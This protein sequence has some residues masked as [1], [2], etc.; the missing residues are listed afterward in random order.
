VDPDGK[1]THVKNKEDGTY[2]V[3]GGDLRD[4]DR[5]IYVYTK[6]KEG[7]YTVRGESIGESDLMTTFYNS[8]ANDGKGAWSVGSVIDPNDNTG[9]DF[10]NSFNKEEPAITDYMATATEGLK[11]D[12]KNA[13]V[14]DGNLNNTRYHYRG[15]PIRTEN[16]K[17]IYS[18]ARDI[19][20]NE[21]GYIAGIHQIPW[22]VARVAFDLLESYQQKRLTTEGMSTQ[23][24][25][26]SG[27]EAGKNVLDSNPVKVY[28]WMYKSISDSYKRF[29]K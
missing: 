19:G 3:I 27:W 4:K 29:F 7:N 20:N 2:E 15:M 11:Y 21:A 16:G 26:R 14:T 6:D 24:A 28:R 5:N 9:I 13:G 1:S 22:D 25:Q 10:F 12:F 17:T 23:N 18:S 8:D